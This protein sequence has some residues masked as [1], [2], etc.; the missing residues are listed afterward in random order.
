MRKKSQAGKFLWLLLYQGGLR[1]FVYAT[2]LLPLAWI[3]TADSFS[4]FS[5]ALMVVLGILIVPLLVTLLT[6]VLL[7][8]SPRVPN[9]AYPL[10]SRENFAWLRRNIIGE[11]VSSSALLNNL[12]QRISILKILY[13]G[14]LGHRRPAHVIFAP[15]VRLLDPDRVRFGG[16]DFIGVATVIGGHTVK[17]T[18][19]ILEDTVIEERVNIGSYCRFAVGVTVGSGTFIDYGVQVGM[20]VRIGS[21]VRIF[22]GAEIDDEAVIDDNVIIGKSAEVG[23]KSRI[24]KGSYVGSYARVA[25]KADVPAGTRIAEMTDFRGR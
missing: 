17:G 9:G 14:I 23:R 12:V 6:A 21:N 5:H 19:L 16:F 8:L 7:R 24:G 1:I 11:F 10:D 15:D 18:T 25:P 2:A 4:R 13:F 20:R 22:A 3:L